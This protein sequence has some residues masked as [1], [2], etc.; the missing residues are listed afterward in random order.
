MGAGGRA[1]S[2]SRSHSRRGFV[3]IAGPLAVACGAF[4]GLRMEESRVTAAL[5]AAT[6]HR[7]VEVRGD[8]YASSDA[9]RSC[10]PR[11][12]ASWSNS[13]HRSMTQVATPQAVIGEFENTELG[14]TPHVRLERQ[15]DRFF[16]NIAG[17][18]GGPEQRYPI[19]LLTGS[20]HMQIY[21]FETGSD[22]TLGQ[23][24][25]VYLRAD[26]RWVPREDIFIEPPQAPRPIANGRWNASCIACHTTHGE[27]RIDARGR[28]DTRVAQF[29]IACEACHGPG[30]G[31]IEANRSPLVRYGKH[32]SGLG[33]A[34]IV[35]PAKLTHERASMVCAQCH[36][37]WL[38]QGPQGMRRWNEH[39]FAYRPGGDLA[40]SML[41]MRPSRAADDPR[42][43]AVI[44][45]DRSFV[46][47]QFWSDGAVRVSGR[48]YNGMVDSK[49]YER[50]TL[51]CMSC[52]EMHPPPNDARPIRAWS[53]DQLGAGMDGDHACLQCHREYEGKLAA[54]TH[55]A[56][57]SDGSRCT[58]CHMPYTSYGLLRAMRSHRIDIPSVSATVA[59]GRPNACN[60]CHLDK[61]LGWTARRLRERYGIE[62][63]PLDDDQDRVEAAAWLGLTGDAG[64]RA[65]VA[66]AM[67]WPPAK[68]ASNE[69]FM[70][71]LLGT[72]MDD[73]Y[74]AVR[75][76]AERSLRSLDNI[77]THDLSYDFVERPDQ[78]A[79]VAPTVSGLG[80]TGPVA[81]DEQRIEMQYD[82]L[83]PRRDD[84]D[85]R[86]LE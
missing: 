29:G 62:S 50:G 15:A 77:D 34:S 45:K 18:R 43:A 2:N 53:S 36:G 79:P 75:Y 71:R 46:D 56:P 59:T 58:N 28:F 40:D 60:L 64:Q 65:L 10:H 35:Q 11:E 57:E 9:C 25:F 81:A 5:A 66:W 54:H 16:M 85:V 23:L 31:H 8:G 1:G 20:H 41:L 76:I 32:W 61:S 27:P 86:L 49:C 26:R 7:P 69:A 67:G 22:R 74:D 78:R 52:H 55:H 84:R 30:E 82:R 17:V 48:E 6:M 39:G 21:W 38:H 72:L 33:D 70:P 14:S 13:Y 63:P 12:Y 68:R 4:G 44:A 47:G 3:R 80:R 24:P 83:K 51:S 19:T 42:I 73:P 37:T